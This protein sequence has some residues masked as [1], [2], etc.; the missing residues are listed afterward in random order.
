MIHVYKNIQF[1]FDKISDDTY[2]QIGEL[3]A[4]IPINLWEKY[5]DFCVNDLLLN[6]VPYNEYE[7]DNELLHSIYI[8]KLINHYEIT[9]ADVYICFLHWLFNEKTD[10][11]D[12]IIRVQYSCVSWMYHDI[13][14][15][16]KHVDAYIIFVTRHE[17]FDALHFGLSEGIKYTSYTYE[18]L[19]K[20]EQL[21]NLRFSRHYADRAFIDLTDKYWRQD[22]F[23][24]EE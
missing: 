7:Q 3:N 16:E 12:E 19:Y 8:N 13:F 20:L 17:E 15:A 5:V 6:K 24:P 11:K 14:H 4:F 23:Q 2:D 10:Y 21:Y 1:D 9:S 18:F 22:E